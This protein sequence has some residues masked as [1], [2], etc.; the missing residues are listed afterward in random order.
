MSLSS[1]L[2]RLSREHAF[3]TPK[4]QFFDEESLNNWSSR[5]R[6]YTSQLR[7]A[8]SNEE[9]ER[10][11]KDLF[12]ELFEVLQESEL[13]GKLTLQQISG[14]IDE[15][16][17]GPG[18]NIGTQEL[19]SFIGKM[20]V[21]VSNQ[22]AD[23]DES[24][25]SALI[26]INSS[27]PREIY[28]F[29]RLASK[30]M[31]NEQTTLLR[32]LLKRSK[33]E[34]KKFNLLAECP[35]GY[36]Q[37]VMLLSS[38]YSDPD[39]VQKVLFYT[40]QMR[41][42]IGKYSLD[43]MRCLD[44]VLDVSSEFILDQHMFF[45]HLLRNSDFWPKHTEA[46]PV[47][48]KGLN[49]GG[50]MLASNVI[51]FRITQ[52]GPAVDQKYLDLVCI[53]I[54][55]GFVSVFS[56]WQNIGPSDDSLNKLLEKFEK[57]LEEESMKGVANPL[58][59][60]DALAFDEDDRAPKAQSKA[61][62]SEKKVNGEPS[63]EVREEPV[64][65]EP[66]VAEELLQSGKLQLLQRLLVH[67]CFEACFHILR[68]N[69][70]LVHLDGSIPKAIVRAFE[71][72][73]DPL[74]QSIV[75]TPPTKLRNSRPV[76]LHENGTLSHK[77]RLFGE[78]K[79]HQPELPFE[80]ETKAVFY[81]SEWSSELSLVNSVEELFKKSHEFYSIVGIGLAMNPRLISKLCRI[82][83]SDINGQNG[84]TEAWID[85]VR[86]FIFP[87]V[88]SLE[89]NPMV[90]NEIYELIE[91][92]PFERRYF[93][94]NEMITKLSQDVL[95]I[96]LSFNK[97]E[98]EAKSMLKALSIDSLDEQ[99]RR[100]ANLVS[101]NP[102][103]TL[104]SAVKQIENYDKVSELM[105]FTAKTFN[106]FAYDVLQFVLLLRLTD[107]RAAVQLDGVNQSMWVQRLSVFIAGLAKS[108][109]KMNL[110]N[111]IEYIVKT[112]HSGNIIAVSILRQ[113]VVTVGGIRDLY[114]VNTK[115]LLMLNSGKP[116]QN[117]AR[118]LMFDFRDENSV[119]GSKLIEYFAKKKT[120]SEVIVLLHNL[121]LKANTQDAHYKILS[122]R[123]DEMNTLLWSFIELVKHSLDAEQF[124]ENVLPLDSLTNSYKVSTPWAFHIWREYIDAH[125]DD[126]KVDIMIK[127]A[128]FE[129]VDFSHIPRDLFITFWKLSLYDVHFNKSLYDERK[130]VLEAELA[131][132]TSTKKKNEVSSHMKDL[133]VSCI[134]HQKRFNQT[135]QS[136]EQQS[137][138]WEQEMT[139][140]SIKSFFQHCAIPRLLFSPPDAI[141]VC[142][143]LL[144]TFD[145]KSAMRLVAYFVRSKVLSTL[146]FCCTSSEAGNLGVFFAQLLE[147]MEIMRSKDQLDRQCCRELY[148]WHEVIT[149]QVVVTL[150]NK[151]YMSIRNGIEFMKHLSHVFPI[152]DSH[153]HLVSQTISR[154]LENEGRE[155][156]K[157]PSNA[158]LGHLKAR[159][160]NAM[161]LEDICDLNAE[162][163]EEKAK[164]EAELEEI[165]V[166]EAQLAN[167]KKQAELRK[168]LELNKIRRENADRT[169]EQPEKDSATAKD[170]SATAKTSTATPSSES[171]STRVASWPFGKVIRFMDEVCTNFRKNNL[172]RALNCILDRQE[173][174]S[175]R[176]LM[177]QA[178]PLRDFKSSLL[179]LYERYF[180]SL[181]NNPRNPEFAKKLDELKASVEHVTR[182]AAKK[183]SDMYSD[184]PEPQEPKKLSR[185]SGS[186]RSEV[187]RSR[188]V[189]SASRTA[190]DSKA[191]RPLPAS[192][193][194]DTRLA[195]KAKRDTPPGGLSFVRDK[196]KETKDERPAYSNRQKRS[197]QFDPDSR[198]R[199]PKAEEGRKATTPVG[200]R[201]LLRSDRPPQR[202]QSRVQAS[203]E[204]NAY[205]PTQSNPERSLKRFRSSDNH[206]EYR[207]PDA[208]PKDLRKDTDRS[209][210]GDRK[211]PALPQG[212]KAT[213]DSQ[214][215]YQR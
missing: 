74:Y 95:P 183:R 204:R 2:D 142:S 182:D 185:Y 58:A 141:Y 171:I 16:S 118:I 99:S 192:P 202:Y 114:E 72:I 28:K 21:A 26:R 17:S 134:S 101:A 73:I 7:A 104:I 90:T 119:V 41:H 20:F 130:V 38:A 196:V 40:K 151:N 46:D 84:S 86:K 37:L 80:L 184:V 82:A 34:L 128:Q 83:R 145:I 78:R 199:G 108:C 24:K 53:L 175:A 59:M 5:T 65:L 124:V 69:P 52:D 132:Y 27:L 147:Q 187:P 1:T 103:A 212:P 54:K 200:P 169:K 191:Q 105:V 127:G 164:Y 178:M 189:N 3:P 33:Y 179:A 45:V 125:G 157:L 120:I 122:V 111:I 156:I 77:P 209:R 60:A 32:H 170:F 87:C 123:C 50:S 6:D 55:N 66:N 18:T 88:A 25:V 56:I 39:N 85:Y 68:E 139:E 75:F 146:L 93:M 167:E 31:N 160:K 62:T 138:S 96:K 207:T 165:K 176:D 81:Y 100:L 153:I 23:C 129:E 135:K 110:S 57:G 195:N 43:S 163:L 173:R 177:K 64:N 42:I 215:R 180:L 91:L 205:E 150:C 48:L 213:K 121:N 211:S 136:L 203:R 63:S 208:R 181:V 44:I 116:L 30:L 76:T 22:Y 137:A 79:T 149:E 97:T 113:L 112:L 210:Y 198:P 214:S 61:D 168:Q 35:T 133:L 143:F 92:F 188:S 117:A 131:N 206:Q 158:L 107:N 166:Y 51:S 12:I 148:E 102:L 98:R 15:I 190:D 9:R 115:Q 36:S 197:A 29:S 159:L 126:D 140:E 193:S 201:A 11:L 94:Y 71:F 70:T 161:K 172:T 49:R 194:A 14:L 152:L 106:D 174:E 19:S 13:P 154:N 109:D 155:D 162:E 47:S 144:L 8:E 10:W 67:G 89:I 4:R 186:T